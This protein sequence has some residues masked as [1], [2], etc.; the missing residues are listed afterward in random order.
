MKRLLIIFVLLYACNLQA[1]LVLTVAGQ[2]DSIGN[3]NG[4]VA[5]GPGMAILSIR[6]E[7]YP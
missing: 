7:I 2:V 5:T 1:Q 3:T 6:S 4:A